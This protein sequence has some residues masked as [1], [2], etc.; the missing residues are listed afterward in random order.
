MVNYPNV[1]TRRENQKQKATRLRTQAATVS[2]SLLKS[3]SPVD[4]SYS[5]MTN[6]FVGTFHACKNK[7]KKKRCTRNFSFLLSFLL[8]SFL[9]VSS[10]LLLVPPSTQTCLSLPYSLVCFFEPMPAAQFAFTSLML[11]GI[12]LISSIE[13]P[14]YLRN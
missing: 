5:C 7:K 8:L 11:P 12:M 1:V 9:R 4:K 13:A 14:R 10:S 3:F 6:C 2:G